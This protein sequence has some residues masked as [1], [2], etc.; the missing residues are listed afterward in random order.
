[1]RSKV[2]V[3]YN[4]DNIAEAVLEPSY[5]GVEPATWVGVVT[6]L[7]GLCVLVIYDRLG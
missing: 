6:V 4:P 2:V 1:M 3:Y 7:L 5:S